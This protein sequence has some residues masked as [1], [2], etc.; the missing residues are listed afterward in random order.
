MSCYLKMHVQMVSL[1]AGHCGMFL[2]VK[3]AKLDMHATICAECRIYII[4]PQGKWWR[5]IEVNAEQTRR[6]KMIR[7]PGCDDVLESLYLRVY[8]CARQ[9]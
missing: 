3:N 8:V 4:S 2:H 7:S 5:V 1:A 6:C 9:L